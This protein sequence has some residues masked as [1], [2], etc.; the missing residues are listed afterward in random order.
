M[1]NTFGKRLLDALYPPACVS[2][3]ALTDAPHGLC[4]ECWS[5]VTFISGLTCAKCS[6]PLPGSAQEDTLCDTCLRHP[7]AWDA[8]QAALLYSGAGRRIVLGL[9]HGDR[10]DLARP[11]A[12]WM[13]RAGSRVLPR[14]DIVAP[15]PL[16]WRRLLQRSFNQASELV[17]QPAIA[18]GRTVLPGLLVRNRATPSQ[19]GKTRAERFDNQRGAIAVAPRQAE[20]IRDRNVLLIDDVLTTGA[21]LS[22]AAE[23]CRAAGAAR[24]DVLVLARVARAEAGTI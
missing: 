23:A 16:H 21:T 3:G 6:V 8:G 13:Q 18:E 1:L 19:D 4:P 7:P 2:C 9:K 11:L 24:V 12:G 14:A 20:R 10:L 17:R 22:A 15:V 5:D